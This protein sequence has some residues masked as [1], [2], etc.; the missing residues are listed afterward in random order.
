MRS[1][2][3][4]ISVTILLVAAM[5]TGLNLSMRQKTDW[6]NLRA[7]NIEALTSPETEVT[8]INDLLCL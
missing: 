1:K 4:K 7:G 6:K 2:Y 3:L 8:N 5:I